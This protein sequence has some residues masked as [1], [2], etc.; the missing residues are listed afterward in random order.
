MN[1]L[2]VADKFMGIKA[3]NIITACYQPFWCLWKLQVV[4][5]GRPPDYLGAINKRFSAEAFIATWLKCS[6]CVSCP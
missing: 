1:L 5:V 4:C 6:S 3:L 2:I